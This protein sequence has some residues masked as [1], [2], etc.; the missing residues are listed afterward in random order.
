MSATS[1]QNGLPLPIQQPGD[2]A[3]TAA[4][5]GAVRSWLW[6]KRHGPEAGADHR[7]RAQAV[8]SAQG[9]RERDGNS[10]GQDPARG[11]GAVLSPTARPLVRSTKGLAL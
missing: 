2:G 8:P 3:G 11:S 6:K 4:G 5:G 10:K 1:N 9:L 7:G